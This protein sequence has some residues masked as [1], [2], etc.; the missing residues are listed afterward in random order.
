MPGLVL[1]IIRNPV[2][3]IDGNDDDERTNASGGDDDS[4]EALWLA[5]SAR[6][7]SIHVRMGN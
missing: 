3:T 6:P 1:P 7:G 5:S 2:D 4:I